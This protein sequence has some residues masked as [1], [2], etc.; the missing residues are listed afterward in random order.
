[1]TVMVLEQAVSEALAAVSRSGEMDPEVQTLRDLSI[2]ARKLAR[3]WDRPQAVGL[4]GP[5]QAGKSF[6][7]G[8]LLA[9]DVGNLSVLARSRELDFLKEINP[10][11]GVES[12]GVVTRF[13]SQVGS[14]APERG[15]FACRLLDLETVLESL[16]TGFLVECTAPPPDGERISRCLREAESA[17]GTKAGPRYLDAWETVLHNLGKKYQDR[18]PYLNELR[19]SPELLAGTYKAR[20]TTV[21]GFVKLF[22]L[23]WGGGSYAPDLDALFTRLHE[24][25]EVVGHATTV[26]VQIEH[27]RASSKD[28]SLIDASCLNAIGRTLAPIRIYLPEHKR[29][30]DVD[31][32]VLSA[33]IAELRLPL[34][35]PEGSLLASADVLDFP[36]GRALKGLNGFGPNELRT[37][38]L[39]HAIEVY[40]RGKLTFLFEQFAADREVTAL[41]LCS[42]GPT[43]PEA[44]QLQTQVESWLRTRFGADTPSTPDELDAPSLFLALTKFDMSLGAL[45]S[46]NAKERWESRVQEACVDFWARS[47]SSWVLNWGARGKAF[48]NMFWVR[49]PYADQMQTL[50]ADTSD[51]LAVKDGYFGARA[52]ARFIENPREKWEAVEG[53]DPDTNL[54]R[55]GIP[56]LAKALLRK[57][58]ENVKQRELARE[59]ELIR[60]EFLAVLRALTP[61]R[62]ESEERT[63]RLELALSLTNA[64]RTEMGKRYSGA[65]FGEFI[66]RIA[67]PQEEVVREVQKS[68]DATLQLSLKA[69]D[70]VKRLLLHTLKWWKARALARLRES[71]LAI[72]LAAAEVFLVETVTSKA[73]LPELGT[74]L[75]PYFSRKT[76]DPELI[77]TILRVRISDAT[78]DLF[79]GRTRR[80]TA[81]PVRLSF[82]E[83]ATTAGETAESVDWTNLDFEADESA[84]S[85]TDAPEIVFAG[86]ERFRAFCNELGP[87]Y[88]RS[89]PENV[90]RAEDDPR[91]K[92]LV[93]LRAKVENDAPTRS[94]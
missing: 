44:I 79:Q 39:E 89:A 12:T 17:G 46:D 18:H 37:G 86:R 7:I 19:R 64:L 83:S 92:T 31:P 36:G 40:K 73:L 87:L 63:R 35:A 54:P 57:L 47:F 53:T 93:A 6:L 34:R 10:A 84:A 94:A 60:G 32:A 75:F 61:S 62:D 23:F 4:F 58:R 91:I 33:L 24:G 45:R 90:Q 27:V 5:S 80:A 49:N 8:A 22:S 21:P 16:A 70:K 66:G 13:S 43:K 48:T 85:P 78:V 72:P 15:E 30:A 88:L 1:M 20:I 11:K 38:S 52:V 71:P 74:A 67:L 2:R 81:L 69:S 29:D 76:V 42:P 9:H 41:V 82:A 68:L 55:S 28:P 56:L 65:P 26:E 59:A 77:A 3:A 50:K 25:L 14:S 51:Y